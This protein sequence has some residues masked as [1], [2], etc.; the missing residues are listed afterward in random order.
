MPEPAETFCPGEYIREEL[1]WRG[2]SGPDLST[3]TGLRLS[4]IHELISG[5]RVVTGHIAKHLACV[6]D[7]STELWLKLQRAWDKSND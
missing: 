3:R 1:D 5:D 4:L 6:F 7:T 2:W